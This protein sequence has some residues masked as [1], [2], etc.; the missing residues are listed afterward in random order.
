MLIQFNYENYKSYLTETSLDLTATAYSELK[1]NLIEGKW[2]EKYMKVISIYGANASGKSNVLEAFDQ[3]K[4]LVLKSFENSTSS[5]EI[6]LKRFQFCE[7]GKKSPSLF[8]VFFSYKGKEYQY[9]F[10]L[11][12]KLIL[13]E[14]LYKRNYR[15]KSKYEPIFE[16]EGQE[17]NLNDELK[18]AKDIIQIMNDKTLLITLL[19]KLEIEDVKNVF[20]WFMETEVINFGNISFEFFVERSLPKVDF[21][22][23]K[24]YGRFV[25][26]LESI[27]VGI[28]GIRKERIS[29]EGIED[30]SKFEKYKIYTQHLNI[31]TGKIEEI[32]L[33]EESSG[34][35]KMMGLYRFVSEAIE[36]GRTLF[37]DE[38][39]AK[40][41]PLLTRYLINLFQNEEH[42]KKGAQLI[43]TTHDTNT[44]TNELFRRDQIWFVEKDNRGISELFSLSEYK[45]G[46][47]KVRKDASYNKDYLGGRYGAIPN[48]GMKVG[49]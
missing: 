34:T 26:F 8:E 46:N 48:I 38:M 23:E 39:D 47:H 40:L 11:N 29:T 27:D 37:V 10:N 44:L 14:W 25:E 17:F 4:K 7:D 18:K 3:M 33:H 36:N 1:E 16:R 2:N 12:E 45:I 35:I 24:E 5:K 20:H 28:K 43:F 42:N 31:D 41:H 19:S 6:P 49:V 30:E 9:G 21:D 15:Y 13:S 22:N 32:P